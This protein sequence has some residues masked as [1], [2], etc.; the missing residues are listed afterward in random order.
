MKTERRAE[1]CSI[2]EVGLEFV[3]VKELMDKWASD[4]ACLD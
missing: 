3:H 4:S 2:K 1:M